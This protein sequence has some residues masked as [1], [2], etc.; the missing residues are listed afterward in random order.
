LLEER[1]D[2][3]RCDCVNAKSA[4]GIELELILLRK[5][6]CAHENPKIG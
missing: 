2:L 6:P 1:A 3:F 4:T 5:R